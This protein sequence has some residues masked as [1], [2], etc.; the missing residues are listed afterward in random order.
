MS[1]TSHSASDFFLQ[2]TSFASGWHVSVLQQGPSQHVADCMNLHVFAS[3]QVDVQYEGSPQS[4]S[5]PAE[6]KK[7]DQDIDVL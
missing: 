3:Q 1:S 6:K 4:H 7:Q 2:M 5:S